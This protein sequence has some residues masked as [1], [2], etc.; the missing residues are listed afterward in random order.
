M[1]KNIYKMKNIYEKK[2][3]GK[4][5]EKRS[6]NVEKGSKTRPEGPKQAQNP[7]V[8]PSGRF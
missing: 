8:H 2:R 4:K 1:Y 7:I 3:V 6:K 5:D